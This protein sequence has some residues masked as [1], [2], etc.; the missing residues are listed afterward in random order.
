[1]AWRFAWT[2][3]LLALGCTPKVHSIPANPEKAAFDYFVGK[4][5]TDVQAAAVVGNLIQESQLD[6]SA[7]EHGG[8]PGRGLAQWSVGGRWDTTDRDN[9]TWYAAKHRASPLGFDTQLDFIW[10]ELTSGA[11]GYKE[12]RAA[13]DLAGATIAFQDRF[14]MC[15]RCE[16]DQRIAYAERVLATYGKPGAPAR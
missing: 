5:L 4:G 15:S 7:A 8:G 3:A 12:L 13:G 14:E 16:Q 6:P 10:F 9:L 2:C 11:Y 1:M